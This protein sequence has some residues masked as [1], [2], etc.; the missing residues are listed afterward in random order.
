M[1]WNATQRTLTEFNFTIDVNTTAIADAV[2]ASTNRTLSYYPEWAD[3]TNYTLIQEV[4]WTNAVRTLTD[5]NFTVEATVN[6]SDVANAVWSYSNKTVDFATTGTTQN[7]STVEDIANIGH[8]YVGGTEYL[9]GDAGKI[10]IRLVKGTGALAEVETGANCTVTL[11]YP[12]STTFIFNQ[13]M[14]EIGDGA[15]IYDFTVPAQLGIYAYYTNCIVE[16]RK[17]FSLN[18]FHVYQNDYSSI[19]TSVWNATTRT[20]TDNG[21][22]ITASDVWSYSTRELTYYPTAN[23]TLSNESIQELGDAVWQYDG[24]ISSNILTQFA[25][26]VTCT[27][28]KLQ[29]EI[30]LKAGVQLVSC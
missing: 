17:Y 16:D 9:D 21:N 28:Q 6:N 8:T 25:D 3:L 27:I 7:V 26:S 19:P 13:S 29:S 5:F 22:D 15:Y 14:T 2:W 11:L 1:V 10:A 24:T 20:L 23:L 12:N 18:D 4:V 30:N